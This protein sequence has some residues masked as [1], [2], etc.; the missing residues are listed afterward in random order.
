MYI[1]TADGDGDSQGLLHLCASTS[2]TWN[3]YESSISTHK[4]VLLTCKTVFM[5]SNSFI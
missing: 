4:H 2:Q 3:I 5:L 1:L